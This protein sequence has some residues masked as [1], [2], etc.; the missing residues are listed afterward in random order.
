[1]DTPYGDYCQRGE[2]PGWTI[3]AL[4]T[5]SIVS[6]RPG[7]LRDY[8]Y[9]NTRVA[10]VE[11]EL[12]VANVEKGKLYRDAITSETSWVVVPGVGHGVP[13]DP[14]GAATIQER[15]LE[16]LRLAEERPD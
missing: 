14:L 16:G 4:Q 7:E 2:G 6:A 3:A 5:E 10:F 12:D 11:G 1:M 9:P 8:H 13:R 15:L